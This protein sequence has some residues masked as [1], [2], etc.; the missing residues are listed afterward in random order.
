[1]VGVRD[2]KRMRAP[3]IDL[4]VIFSPPPT[5]T[6]RTLFNNVHQSMGAALLLL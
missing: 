1:M 3:H 4:Y 5:V 6:L 2:A